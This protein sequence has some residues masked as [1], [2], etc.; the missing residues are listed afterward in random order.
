MVLKINTKRSPS[1][2]GSVGREIPNPPTISNASKLKE[3]GVQKM[4]KRK[5]CS[6]LKKAK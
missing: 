3:R 5:S 6:I 4:I 1:K 2:S